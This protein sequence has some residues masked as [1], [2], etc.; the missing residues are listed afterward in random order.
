V[1]QVV[2]LDGTGSWDPNFQTGSALSYL[3]TM[4]LRPAGSTAAL[5]APAS[6]RPTFVADVPG[7]YVVRL[8]VASGALSSAPREIRITTGNSRPVADAGAPQ[9]VAAGGTVTLD[10]TRSTDVNGDPLSY[11][12]TFVTTPAG[13]AA[14]ISGDTLPRATFVADVPGVYIAQVVVNDGGFVDAATVLIT[15]ANV[16]P[17]GRAG[18]DQAVPAPSAVSAGR[19]GR[20]RTPVPL[21]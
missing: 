15:T 6:P 21:P 8:V 7:D 2:H 16:A 18:A 11:Q 13:S 5:T 1:G 20:G 19:R 9:T 14:A 12:W 4:P 3:W 10:G 17:I